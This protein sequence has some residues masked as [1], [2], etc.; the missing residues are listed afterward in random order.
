MAACSEGNYVLDFQ[1]RVQH[2]EGQLKEMESEKER[3]LNALRKEKRELIHT[4]QT[5]RRIDDTVAITITTTA[6]A[7]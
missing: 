1:E 7:T 5:V 2:L 4:S 3:E 6:T